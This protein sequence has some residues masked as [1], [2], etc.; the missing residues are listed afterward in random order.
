MLIFERSPV[1]ECN[2]FLADQ[3]DV[4]FINHNVFVDQEW[5][6]FLVF[7]LVLYDIEQDHGVILV[8]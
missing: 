3:Q 7:S 8:L 6:R 4:L 2:I 1:E 5:H